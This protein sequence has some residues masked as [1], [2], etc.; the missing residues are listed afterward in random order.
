MNNR[1]CKNVLNPLLQQLVEALSDN[2]LQIHVLVIHYLIHTWYAS[3]KDDY[4]QEQFIIKC[5]NTVPIQSRVNKMPDSSRS[6]W[7]S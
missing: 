2:S 4:M 6:I 3:S 7:D 1:K 5:A